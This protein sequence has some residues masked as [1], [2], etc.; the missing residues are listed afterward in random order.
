ME[1]LN[2]H[3]AEKDLLYDA[4]KSPAWEIFGYVFWDARTPR[5]LRS[6]GSPQSIFTWIFKV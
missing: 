2:A 5:K 6:S 1:E 3:K 4:A